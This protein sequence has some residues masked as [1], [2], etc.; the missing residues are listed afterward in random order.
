MISLSRSSLAALASS[1]VAVALA[2]AAPAMASPASAGQSRPA[3]PTAYVVNE[4]GLQVPGTVTPIDTATGVAG[5]PIKVGGVPFTIAITPNGKTAYVTDISRNVVTPITTATDKPGK[6]IKVGDGPFSLA[7]T[8]NGKT[9]YVANDDSG[10]VTPISTS[11]NKAGRAIAVGAYPIPIAA[12]ANGRTVYS[13]GATQLSAISTA[14]NKASKPLGIG[15]GTHAIAIS[16]SSKTVYVTNGNSLLRINATTLRVTKR[17][18]VGADWAVALTP[19]GATIYTFSCSYAHPATD[20]MTAI[21][22]ASFRPAKPVRLGF[23]AAGT[24]FTPNGKTMYIVDSPTGDNSGSVIPVNAVTGKPGPRV[25]VGQQPGA[26]A[27]LAGATA[28]SASTLYVVNTG[29]DSVTTVNTATNAPTATIGVG[30][31][32]TSIGLAR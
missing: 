16:P 13:V 26:L 5:A 2:V 12:A 30:Y 32:P 19:N 11:T 29:S 28:S 22:V 6:P 15:G 24:A 25:L 17:I 8:P 21:P 18:T 31:L 20:S 7:I 9:V 23:C 3:P 1:A 14:T 4:G 27:V 10:T